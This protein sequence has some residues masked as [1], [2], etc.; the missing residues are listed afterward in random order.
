M[1]IIS[2]LPKLEV[3]KLKKNAF[4]D[5]ENV[6]EDVWEVTEM[7]FPKLKFLLLEWLYLH[8]WRATDDYFPR[9]ERIII[10]SCF[11]IKE[12]PEG[13]ADSMT[14]QLIELHQCSSSLVNSAKRIQKEQLE[15]LGNDMLKVY[16][17][18]TISENII[19]MK[20]QQ[21]EIWLKQIGA[22]E[23]NV[24]IASFEDFTKSIGSNFRKN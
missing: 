5:G 14:L 19:Q 6:G 23:P 3:L 11:F 7:G 22:L 16:A 4:A 13:F 20:N 15:N 9:L 1:T 18:D 2:M 12:I 21:R 10:R 24:S 8:Y 17:Y